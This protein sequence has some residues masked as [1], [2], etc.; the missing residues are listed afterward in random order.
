MARPYRVVTVKSSGQIIQHNEN[1]LLAAPDKRKG[2]KHIYIA[3]PMIVPD[4]M[5]VSCHAATTNYSIRRS[6]GLTMYF[7]R[8]RLGKYI[9]NTAQT[10]LR[11]LFIA[12]PCA[13]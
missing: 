9:V 13:V 4:K 5:S 12:A 8:L 2:F 7:P 10:G 11:N 3:L 1:A 6:N